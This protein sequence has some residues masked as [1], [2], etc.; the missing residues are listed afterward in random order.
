[1]ADMSAPALWESPANRIFSLS[2]RSRTAPSSRGPADPRH[3]LEPNPPPSARVHWQTAYPPPSSVCHHFRRA[4]SSD[5]ALFFVVSPVAFAMLL[6]MAHLPIARLS[7]S[8][9]ARISR[10]RFCGTPPLQPRLTTGGFDR[11]SRRLRSSPRAEPFSS[12][13]MSGGLLFSHGRLTTNGVSEVQGAMSLSDHRVFEQL[14]AM[15]QVREVWD[16]LA[17]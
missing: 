6:R 5:G 13:V 3:G 14:M 10:P 12:I 17:E 8:P 15:R 9:P 16:A 11:W 2:L 7:D 1:M 4:P